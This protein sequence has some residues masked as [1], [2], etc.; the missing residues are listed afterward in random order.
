[1][2]MGRTSLVGEVLKC[3]VDKRNI[4]PEGFHNSLHWQLGHISTVTDEIVFGKSGEVW[5][6]PTEFKAFFEYGTKPSTWTAE[7]PPWDDVLF[8]LT[9]QMA[10]IR[11]VFAG[12]LDVKVKTNP[13]KGETVEE[14]LL[15]N[16]FHES[17]HSGNILAM[18]KCFGVRTPI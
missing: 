18:L 8:Q 2:E 7:P 13:F 5:S 3:P 4:V 9:D 16:L 15:F 10:N 11:K 1:M 17:I 12:K 14:L 6:V